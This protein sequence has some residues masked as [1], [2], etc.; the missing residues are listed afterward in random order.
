M[1]PND[2]SH[3]AENIG[4]AVVVLGGCVAIAILFVRCALN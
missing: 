2:M 4:C 1:T 3:W